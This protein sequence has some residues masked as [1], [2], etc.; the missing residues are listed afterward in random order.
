MDLLARVG[1]EFHL[2]GDF[3]VVTTIF[4]PNDVWG[5]FGESQ[6]RFAIIR[7]VCIRL[8]GTRRK[9]KT[10]L[11]GKMGHMPIYIYTLIE[12]E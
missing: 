12:K 8:T 11:C 1:S 10:I 7:A 3:E 9:L 5:E 6:T 2:C 4:S